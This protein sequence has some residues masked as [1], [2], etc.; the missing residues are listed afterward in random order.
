MIG[1]IALSSSMEISVRMRPVAIISLVLIICSYLVLRAD[2]AQ[3]VNTERADGETT[4]RENNSSASSYISEKVTSDDKQERAGFLEKGVEPP[5]TPV[6]G[7]PVDVISI[8]GYIS[9]DD[10]AA[11]DRESNKDLLS[12]GVKLSADSDEGWPPEDIEP[13]ALGVDFDADS[14]GYRTEDDTNNISV[15]DYVNVEAF[16]SGT[17]PTE[18]PS[19]PISIG[20]FIKAPR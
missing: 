12:V 20:E 2:P 8:G 11:F 10:D 18:E 15:G 6:N 3:Q 7:S 19:S 5:A 14:I 1:F 16:L 13:I 9:P 4:V 17:L